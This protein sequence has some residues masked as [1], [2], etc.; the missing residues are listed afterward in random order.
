LPIAPIKKHIGKTKRAIKKNNTEKTFILKASNKLCKI[1][2]IKKPI[3]EIP[4]KIK[5]NFNFPFS[6]DFK[7]KKISTIPNKE[8]K[9]VRDKKRIIKILLLNPNFNKNIGIMK[10]ANRIKIKTTINK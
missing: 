9:V 8:K 3:G 10:I 6:F 4:V 1:A 2:L 7:V 5:N